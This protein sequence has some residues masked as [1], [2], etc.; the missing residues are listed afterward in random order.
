MDKPF[1]FTAKKFLKKSNFRKYNS[2]KTDKEIF[3]MTFSVDSN[4]SYWSINVYGRNIFLCSFI[5][6]KS[7]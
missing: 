7:S 3:S 1:D 6:N 5:N 2:D 4:K